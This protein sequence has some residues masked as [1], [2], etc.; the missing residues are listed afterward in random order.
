VLALAG[1]FIVVQAIYYGAYFA[2]RPQL[3]VRAVVPPALWLP[4]MMLVLLAG[5]SSRA[6]RVLR[7]PLDAIVRGA[8]YPV[9]RLR[10][11]GWAATRPAADRVLDM[12]PLT[13]MRQVYLLGAYSLLGVGVLAKGPPGLA[14]AGGVGLC[15]VALQRRWRALAGG[16]FEIKR[17]LL[18]LV[19]TSVPWHIA[20]FLKDGIVFIQQYL[21]FHIRDRAAA[22]V[23]ASPGTFEMYS[24]QLGVGM[25]LWAAL[26]PAALAAALLRTRLDSRA[27][28][29]R[30]LIAI[31]AIVSV[32]VF[33]LVQTKFHHYILPAVAPLGVLVAFF[34]D[35][36]AARRDH[37]H[38]L[39]AAIGVAIVLLICRDLVHEP[40]QWIEMLTYRYDRPW[41]TAEP[42]SVD[43]SDGFLALGALG[44]LAIALAATR[45]RRI[46]VAAL[47]LAGLAI[48][49]WSL[50]VYMPIAGTHW[51]MRDAM[52]TYYDLRTVYGEKLVYFGLGELYDDWH[53][54]GDRR[55][56]E[57]HIPIAL[58]VGQPMTVAIRVN[59]ARD[60][61]ITEHELVL[62]GAVTAIGDHRVELALAPGERAR[63]APLLAGG[64]AAPR[65]RPPIR[66]V[67]ADRLIAWQLYW[68]GENF[69]STEE[70][71]G[72]LPELKGTFLKTGATELP[73]YL[74]DARRAP[75]GRRVFVVSDPGHMSGLRGVLPTQ[76]ARDTFELVDT[77][78]NKFSLA[79]FAP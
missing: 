22:G 28:R 77:T 69:W 42:W 45:W 52:R 55:T 76:R 7:L 49:V 46:G 63:L 66:I 74:N 78:S 50:Q 60:E 36:V 62:V 15:H 19:A 71:W 11:G 9:V 47:G 44:A 6:W 59:S 24:A 32:A 34:L 23:D 68:R 70:I 48:C 8:V 53:A 27:D 1:G 73:G 41:P 37:L 38:P 2:A 17:G 43:A 75:P 4:A 30:F 29:V 21:L 65:G 54:A 3:A 13:T 33:G 58:Q 61:R 67:D 25:W 40:E 20:M 10:G 57:T 12:A 51:G 5:L 35:D 64:A 16:A 79:V 39:H 26:L 72:P 31:W 56:F 18:L 14:I